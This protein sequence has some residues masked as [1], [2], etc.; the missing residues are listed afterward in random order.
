MPAKLLMIQGTAS[1]VGKSIIVTALCRIFKQ[2]GFQ[3]APFKAQN[4]ALNSY[5]TREG[6]EMGRAQVVQAEACGLE[7]CV[8]MNPI[9]LKPEADSRS[10]VIVCGKV[11][12]SL[13]AARY[14]EHTPYLFSIVEECLHR[15]RQAY[16]IVVIEGAGSPAEINL[17]EKEIANMRLAKMASSPVLLVGDIDRGGVFAHLVGTLELLTG[18]E[19]DYIKGFII[20]KFRGDLQL[21]RPGLETLQ[22]RTGKGVLGVIPYFRGITIAQEDSV[23]LEERKKNS[24]TGGNLDIAILHLPHISNY[25]DFDPLEMEGCKLRYID[26]ATELGEPDLIILPGSK[27]TI[28]DLLHLWRV[29]LAEMVIEQA[30]KGTAIIGVCGGYQMLGRSIQDPQRIESSQEGALGLGLLDI[31]TIFEASKTTTQ[32]KARVIADRGL[33]AGMTRQE[34]MGYEIHMGQTKSGETSPFHIFETPQ[35]KVARLDG[36]L[37]QSGLILGTY[38]HGLFHNAGFRRAFLHT[39]EQRQGIS[40]PAA[41]EIET[42]ERQ[43]DRLAELVRSSLDLAAIYRILDGGI[44]G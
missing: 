22:S 7:P 24:P 17:K 8:D 11:A 42:R 33:L 29:G 37:D 44:D 36:A 23:Y 20:N 14:Y 13:T 32:V 43:Y 15:M 1:S 21:L 18:E 12:E 28:A 35:G 27:S 34:I 3:V 9:L 31:L 30:R 38:L 4:M 5:V 6:G 25:D 16:D 41:T 19:R 39:L 40:G 2:D 26:D 10:Q